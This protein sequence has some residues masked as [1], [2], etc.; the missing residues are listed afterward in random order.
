MPF[1]TTEDGTQIFYKDWGPS[2]G[3]PVLLSHGWPLN[4]D[5]WEA[6]ALFLATHGFRAIA[7]DRRGHGKSTQTWIGNE[8]D[9]YADDLACLFSALDLTRVSLIGHSTGG[10]EIV[11]YVGRHGSD[12]IAKVVLVSAVPPFMVQTDTNPSGLPIAVFDGTRAGEASNRSQLYRDL[13]DGPFFG[14]NRSGT[15]PQGMR[16]AFWLQG[17]SSG[18]RN[19]Y[20]C[21]AAFSAT[22]FRGDLA[23]IDVPTLVIHG[24]VDQIVPFDIS[25]KLSAQL[26]PNAQLIVYEGGAHGLPDTERDRLHA[27]LLTFLQT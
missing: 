27:D 6:T 16:D 17:L 11:R 18:T 8:M 26:I 12:R 7:H 23:K 10:G 20:E 5:A 13:A 2:D 25:G 24:D 3:A 4:S 14:N 9:T 19:A 1:V 22:D 15:V 21:I